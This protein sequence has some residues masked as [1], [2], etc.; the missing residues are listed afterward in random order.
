MGAR[1]NNG[2]YYGEKSRKEEIEERDKARKREGEGEKAR[3]RE[4]RGREGN[5]WKREGE[6]TERMDEREGEER[7]G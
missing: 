4:M 5:S 3:K 2:G 1:T 7:V 6:G